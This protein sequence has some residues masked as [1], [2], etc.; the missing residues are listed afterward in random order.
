M[1]DHTVID[2]KHRQ[3]GFRR[4]VHTHATSFKDAPDVDQPGIRTKVLGTG[5]IC[6]GTRCDSFASITCSK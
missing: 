6:D 1:K 4:C 3:Q 2:G 5:D